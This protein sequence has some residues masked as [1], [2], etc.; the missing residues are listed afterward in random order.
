MPRVLLVE[1]SP[2]QAKQ[3]AL[4]LEEAGFSVLTSGDAE[5]GYARLTREPFDVVLTDLVLPSESGFDLCRRIKK[6]PRLRQVPVVVLT[7]QADPINVLRGL[8]AGADGFMTKNRGPVEII[9]RLRRTLDRSFSVA[10]DGA[11]ARVVFL[12]CEFDLAVS[13]KQ[14][15]NVLLSA[16]EDVVHLNQQYQLTEVELRHVNTQVQEALGSEHDALQELRKAQSQLVQSEKLASLGQLAAGMAHEINNPL[17]YVLNNLAVLHRDVQA[18][19]EVLNKY[20]E[21]REALAGVNPPL[22]AE[23]ARLEVEMDLPYFQENLVRLFDT[24]QTGLKRVRDIVKNLRDFA[25]LDQAEHKDVDLVEALRS[26]IEVLR[27]EIDAKKLQVRTDVQQLPDVLCEP[28]KM[29]LVFLNLLLNAIQ[30]CQPGGTVTVRAQCSPYAPREEAGQAVVI[31]IEDNGCG[32]PPEHLPRIFEPFFTT[33]PPGQGMGLGLSISYG[34]IR[35]HGGSISVDS[36]PGRGSV[37]HVKVP[38][39]PKNGPS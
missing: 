25:R 23:A 21:G 8:E 12:D 35:E 24:S 20:R 28:G 5:Q 38:L 29:N 37:F 4:L 2:T 13:K 1:D 26:T 27:H 39:M 16:F 19:M 33:K 34:I 11:P 7:S 6:D 31:E 30:A 3:L 15:L 18:A 36:T 22:A 14:L 9:G 10:E 32:I 17:S